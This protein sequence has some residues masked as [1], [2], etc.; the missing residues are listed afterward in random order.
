MAQAIVPP[1]MVEFLQG[2]ERSMQAAREAVAYVQQQPAAKMRQEGILKD[3][4]AVRLRA[5]LPR[6][7]KITLMGFNYRA[8]AAEMLE[9]VPEYP[10]LFSAYPTAVIGPGEPIVIARGSEKPD[11]EA[12]FGVVIGKRGRYV[13]PERAMEH[14]AG[15]LIVNDA[16]DR[17]WQR[18]TSQYLIGK[19][20]DT[21]KPMGP[22][23]VTKD[24]IPDPHKLA[25]KLW[26]NGELRQDSNTELQIFKIWD[27]IAYMSTFWTL[28]PGDVLST[29]TPP[30][31][32][33]ARKPP[34]Y[35]KPGD[36][37]RIEI[38]GLGVLENPV[39]KAE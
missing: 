4:Q 31:V 37:I 7:T 29:G 6:P 35:L 10:L 14:V 13:P 1:D 17:A 38:T 21:M 34:V 12:E 30:G 2:E 33:H 28:E 8:H 24:E 27:V 26:V 32:G 15:Y 25:I 18:R 9:K 19:S 3:L 16:T 39:V 11:Y 5:P 20:V 36:R 22:Y 23:L